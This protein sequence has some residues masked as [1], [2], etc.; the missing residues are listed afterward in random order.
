MRVRTPV[1][2][3]W[4]DAAAR[5]EYGVLAPWP[6]GHVLEYVARRPTV[7]DNFG[8][9]NGPENFLLAE[10]YT[11]SREPQALAIADRLRVR[12]VVAQGA[13]KYLASPPPPDS[14]FRSLYFHDGTAYAVG[15]AGGAGRVEA[16][17]R[18]RLVFESRALELG[19]S[20]EP[21]VYKVFEVVPGARVE[22]RAEPGAPV[23]AVVRVT[24]NRLR[25][26]AY[27]AETE[28]DAS[29]QYALTL[30]Y[31]NEGAPPSVRVAPFYEVRS[32]GRAGR[33]VLEEAQVARGAR[34]D[35]PDLRAAP[36]R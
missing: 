25:R 30:P 21:S 16:L 8:D 33:L 23:E 10:R 6:L 15:G 24:T 22:G 32:R 2:S 12:Y 19:A 7:V 27:R 31:A 20:D 29:G 9:D 26:V 28:A 35:G 1:T 36:P 14:V 13:D 11:R 5:P 4:M 18:H 3:G 34:V 17:R